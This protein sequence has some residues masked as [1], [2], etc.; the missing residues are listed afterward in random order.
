[1]G[2]DNRGAWGRFTA[3]GDASVERYITA[4]VRRVVA[5]WSKLGCARHTRALVMLGGYGRG[6]GG[7]Q[8]VD[9]AQRPHNNLDFLLITESLSDEQMRRLESALAAEMLSIESSTVVGLDLSV[10]DARHLSRSEPRLIWYD[11][12]YGHKTIAGD[13]SFVRGL[14][15]QCL[16]AI[17]DWD[18]RNLLVNRGT[19]LLINQILLERKEGALLNTGLLIKHTMKAVIGYG[20]ALLYSCN[21]YHWSYLEKQRRMRQLAVVSDTFKSLYDEAIEF[22]FKPDY[23][24]YPAEGLAHWL[25][26]I[27]GLLADV[28]LQCERRRLG[29]SELSWLEYWPYAVRREQRSCLRDGYR[30]T[31]AALLAF[32]KSFSA[33]ELLN[34]SALGFRQ[35]LLSERRLVPLL[36]PGMVYP[37]VAD[38][39]QRQARRIVGV[40]DMAAARRIYLRAW[41]KNFDGNAIK[42]FERY[43]IL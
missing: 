36:F 24:R 11:M 26:G 5:A 7:V 40:D 19:L 33:N 9:N 28:H 35:R 22:R 15:R 4:L 37:F 6:E 8:L 23:H 31:M 1:M 32:A 2:N 39:L 17:P 10:I 3:Y 14:R 12:R 25:A 29:R 41:A 13:A 30:Q 16:D 21:N 38:E 42:V 34:Y 20:D 27:L 18:M 43:G